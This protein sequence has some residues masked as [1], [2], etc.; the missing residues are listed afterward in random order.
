[1]K[2]TNKI[3]CTTGKNLLLLVVLLFIYTG[4][5]KEK[6]YS[7]NKTF[8]LTIEFNTFIKSKSGNTPNNIVDIN[9][10]VF[11]QNEELTKHIYLNNE[12][13]ATLEINYGIKTIAAIA[14]IGNQDLSQF[15][16]LSL[17]RELKQNS[18]LGTKGNMIFS[19]ELT[20]S[21]SPNHKNVIIPLTK[22]LS[23]ITY[24]F[25]KSNLDINTNI[26]I[27]KIQLMNT[28]TE[29]SYFSS[30]TPNY[31]QIE[32]DGEILEGINLEPQSHDHAVPLYMFENMQG[33]IGSNSNQITKYPQSKENVC[34][35]VEI[36]ADYNSPEQ[37]GTIKYRN[38]LGTNTTNNYDVIRGK[39][40]K[41]TII[42]N[43]TSINEISW[44]V[45]V[46]NL[47]PVPPPNIAVTGISL[48]NSTL[49]LITGDQH[50]LHA[51]I[52]PLD[53]TNNNCQWSSSNPS[54]VSVSPLTGLLT[55]Y[56]YGL[57]IITAKSCD[58][59]FTDRCIVNVYDPI[60]LTA[61]FCE[62]RTYNITT[63]LI[64]GSDIVIYLRANISSPSNM[65][66]IKAIKPF[67]NVNL[68]YSYVLDNI[69]YY[70]SGSVAL[71]DINN[72]D[73]P[74]IN[75]GGKNILF[76]FYSP[77]S[78]EEILEAIKSITIE[79]IPGSVYAY[80]WYVTW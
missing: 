60:T 9:L 57:A 79:V 23:K 62:V 61:S 35:Y 74:N 24:L 43:G 45:D 7:I 77:L 66:I 52:L 1:M 46:S 27:T 73:I 28:P 41:E 21:F 68:S 76:T 29:C 78:E 15:S 38:F 18:M 17:L 25:D 64:E 44:R 69:R 34:T 63:D 3:L 67:V 56:R 49:K 42:F 48:S 12:S 5:E 31:S 50:Q 80:N 47:H 71:N 2:T 53:A 6:S 20:Q 72:N 16:S 11:D 33:T 32:C 65:Q 30:N 36:T 8:P 26:S 75:G 54:V 13:S 4:C 58:G 22:T 19:G 59:D 37:T 40:Y 10:F 55:T 51:T 14:N 70:G 39:H